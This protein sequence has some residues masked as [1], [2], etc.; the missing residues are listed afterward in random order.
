MNLV[1]AAGLF[2]QPWLVAVV[3]IAG[4]I[5]NWLSQRRQ[6]KQQ[7]KE[8]QRSHGAAPESSP[9]AEKA[10]DVEEALRRL[11]GEEP[12]K[13]TAAPPPIPPT[14]VKL[15][16]PPPVG[17]GNVNVP[18]LVP[19]LIAV[20]VPTVASVRISDTTEQ[21]ALRLARADEQVQ[22][23]LAG[24][25]HRGPARS[26]NRNSYWRN[27]SSVRRAFVGSLVFGPPKGLES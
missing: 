17:R 14:I 11:L 10:F 18:M 19:P 24:G 3:V 6:E 15:P 5:I 7:Q 1:F 8:E 16:S 27:R 26:G 23:S 4:A 25:L 13:P 12:L 22:H 9:K 20:A 21:A 2:D